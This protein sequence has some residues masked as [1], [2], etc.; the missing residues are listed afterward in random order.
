MIIV[1]VVYVQ[2]LQ[3]PPRWGIL[4]GIGIRTYVAGFKL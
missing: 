3:I 1:K 2:H 4:N